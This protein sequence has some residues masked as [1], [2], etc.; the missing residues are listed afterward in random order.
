MRPIGAEAN[1]QP[2]TGQPFDAEVRRGHNLLMPNPPLTVYYSPAYAVDGKMET[3]SKSKLV[4]ALI[5]AGE[6]GEVWLEAPKPATRQELE[7]I[8]EAEY[9]RHTLEDKGA[10]LEVGPWSQPLVDSILASTGGMRD[11]VKEALKNGRSGSLSSGL[12]HARRNSGNG[13]CQFNGLALAALEA[14]KKVKTVGI[15]DL[16]AH[17][18]GGTFDILGDHPQVCLADV[19]VNAFDSW[20]PTDSRRHYYAEVTDPKTYLDRVE[21]ALLT[22]ERVDFLIYNAGMDTYEKAG[23]MKGITKDIIRRREKRVVE[24][25]RARKIPHIFALAGG[26]KWDG[27]TLAQV[28][29]LHLETVKAFAA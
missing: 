11:A 8:H 27:L 20:E 17:A 18:G 23:G 29:E 1:L 6:A 12:H 4:A 5:E 26:Y 21:E 14:L 15:L 9:V 10:F 2:M 3:V 28:A 22:L 7:L 24:W 19:T 16:D 25:A 13:F